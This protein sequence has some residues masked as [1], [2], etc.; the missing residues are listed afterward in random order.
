LGNQKGT[1]R[2]H[3][4]IPGAPEE[5][6]DKPKEIVRKQLGKPWENYRKTKGNHK[7]TTQNLMKT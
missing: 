2:K 7:T 1:I 6:I 5:H 4:K 3:G